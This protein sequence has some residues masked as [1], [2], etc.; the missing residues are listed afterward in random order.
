MRIMNGTESSST[1]SISENPDT[2]MWI[3]TDKTTAK[4]KRISNTV[5]SLTAL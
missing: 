1:S 3:S 2:A 4:A 5:A